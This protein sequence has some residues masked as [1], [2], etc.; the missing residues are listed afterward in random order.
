MLL[1]VEKFQGAGSFSKYCET[2]C[3]KMSS[4][5][6]SLVCGPNVVFVFSLFSNEDFRKAE[7]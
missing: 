7:N 4:C 5:A 1:F 2:I 3:L 6:R